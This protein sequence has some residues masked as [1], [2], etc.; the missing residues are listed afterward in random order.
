MYTYGLSMLWCFH[1]VELL[2]VEENCNLCL[3]IHVAHLCCLLLEE[4]NGSVAVYLVHSDPTCVL[5]LIG[6]KV[7]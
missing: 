3:V 2:L 4:E 7:D 1:T 5:S 6:S